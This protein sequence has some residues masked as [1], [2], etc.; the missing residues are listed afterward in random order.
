MNP[1]L[2]FAQ[3][4]I[5]T[6]VF[7]LVCGGRAA[8][9]VEKTDRQMPQAIAKQKMQYQEQGNRRKISRLFNI[10]LICRTA[11]Q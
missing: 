2:I 9:A 3:T 7:F 8:S 1:S 5:M 10:H 4:I 6:L 11:I